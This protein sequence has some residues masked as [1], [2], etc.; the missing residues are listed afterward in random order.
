MTFHSVGEFHVLLIFQVL[1]IWV[2]S[3]F[4]V[5]WNML[6]IH[7]YIQVLWECAFSSLGCIPWRRS[8][9]HMI[10]LCLT[11]WGT[12][13]PFSKRTAFYI[14]TSSVWSFQFLHIFSNTCYHL[15]FFYSTIL[16]GVKWYIILVLHS[17]MVQDVEH[18]YM[19]FLA[20]CTSSLEKCLFRSIFNWV[21]LLFIQLFFELPFIFELFYIYFISRYKSLIKKVTCK[22]VF[23]IL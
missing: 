11:F 9:G 20:S 6:I 16:V 18:L 10:T 17:L 12:V 21:I 13:W 8:A 15:L 2:V 14:P 19:C 23:L 7:I 4:W 22:K 3:T 5:L 1:D